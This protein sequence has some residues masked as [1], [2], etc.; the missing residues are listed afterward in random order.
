M[1]IL[2]AIVYVAANYLVKALGRAQRRAAGV[3][4]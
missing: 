2:W 3:E 1:F 4:D